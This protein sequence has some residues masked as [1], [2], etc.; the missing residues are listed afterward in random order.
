MGGVYHLTLRDRDGAVKQTA[1][2]QN[3][4]VN[5]G[6]QLLL[7]TGLSGSGYQANSYVGVIGSVTDAVDQADT[8]A[9]HDGW[10]EGTFINARVAPT[11]NAASNGSKQSQTV[12]VYFNDVGTVQGVFLVAGSG[13]SPTPGNT[14]GTLFSAGALVQGN[15]GPVSAGERLDLTYTAGLTG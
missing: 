2:V 10:T 13:A 3:L 7:D 15:I 8:T 1:I 4:L 9:T 6:Y 5:S 12:T 14:S 11:W